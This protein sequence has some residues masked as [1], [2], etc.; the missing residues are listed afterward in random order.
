MDLIS[1]STHSVDRHSRVL[2]LAKNYPNNYTQIVCDAQ[3]K[4][5][6]FL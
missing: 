4:A 1:S 6:S 3:G 2:I 5:C